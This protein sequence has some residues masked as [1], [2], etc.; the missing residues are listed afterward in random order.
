MLAA[1]PFAIGVE[2]R[3][4]PPTT[5]EGGICTLSELYFYA[6]PFVWAGGWIGFSL[7]ISVVRRSALK[8][9][10]KA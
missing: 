1:V 8:E 10:P 2:G 3:L 6:I 4:H 5:C 9:N 7:L